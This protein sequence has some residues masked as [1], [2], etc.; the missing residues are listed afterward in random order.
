MATGV[1]KRHSRQCGHW[2][3]ERC[4]CNAGYEAWVYIARERG[5]VRK[6]FQRKADAESWRSKALDEVNRGVLQLPQRD[7][8]GLALALEQLLEGMRDGRVRP[9][10]RARYKPATIRNYEQHVRR[11]IGPTLLGSMRVREIRRLDI[12]EF[13]DEL[14]AEGLSPSTVNNILNPIQALYRR[15][16]TREEVFYNP[17]EQIEIPNARSIRPKRIAAREEAAELIGALP[18]E[19]RPIWA[20]AFYAGLRRGELQGLRC[21]DVDLERRT[22]TVERGWDQYE[23]PIPPKSNASYRTVPLLAPL[24]EAL[25]A[26]L[27]RVKRS[28]EELIFGR[29]TEVPFV[30]ST[31]NNHA[32]ERWERLG[33]RPITMHECRHTFAS[34]LIDAGANPKALQAF[35]GHSNIQITFDTYGHLLP[36]SREE[37]RKLMDQYL[38]HEAKNGGAPIADLLAHLAHL[39]KQ[40]SA[41]FSFPSFEIG[42]NGFTG[43]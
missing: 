17:T 13:V 11:R 35:M 30:S 22:I 41:G 12:Q 36:G 29:S 31:I 5:K 34:L 19:E 42:E 18:A 37:V 23:G 28:G 4:D 14:L 7:P 27:V 26:H 8:R 6:C 43:R 21:S 1:R 16:R 25:A 32:Q 38:A 40:G 24:R 3:K 9:R 39:Q 2:R 10:N 15:A 33:L 20:T